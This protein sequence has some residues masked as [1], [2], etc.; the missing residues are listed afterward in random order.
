MR[1]QLLRTQPSQLDAAHQ[2]LRPMHCAHCARL[3]SPNEMS[4]KIFPILIASQVSV[5]IYVMLRC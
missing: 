4:I 5:M 3:D 1:N 2:S